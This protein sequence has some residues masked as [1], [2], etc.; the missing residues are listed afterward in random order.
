MLILLNFEDSGGIYSTVLSTKFCNPFVP[1]WRNHRFCGT[2]MGI[3]VAQYMDLVLI[4]RTTRSKS[5]SP[6]SCRDGVPGIIF[7]IFYDTSLTSL[8]V[9]HDGTIL[10][11][12]LVVALT[13]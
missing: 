12:L 4:S 6:V 9:M 8:G 7:F 5:S 10:T 13:V 2:V 11:M 3:T 1:E